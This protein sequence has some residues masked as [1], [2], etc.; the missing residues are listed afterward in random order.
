MLD[1][2]LSIY[3]YTCAVLAIVVILFCACFFS[4]STALATHS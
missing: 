3:L 2:N 1:S 4:L